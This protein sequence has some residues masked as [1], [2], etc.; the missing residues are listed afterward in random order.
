MSTEPTSEPITVIRLT[1]E[2][3]LT[4]DLQ[5][6]QRL[7]PPRHLVIDL[8]AITYVASVH[9][10]ILLKIRQQLRLTDHELRLFALHPK[11]RELFRITSLDVLIE[12]HD[13]EQ[14]AVGSLR[15]VM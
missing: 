11:V 4:N 13:T 3:R 14:Q 1:N 8:S 7:T 10:A 5:A 15:P 6:A 9:L 2:E 12:L